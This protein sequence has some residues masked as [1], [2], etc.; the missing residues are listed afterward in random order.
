M[1]KYFWKFVR[2]GNQSR[3]YISL[4]IDSPIEYCPNVSERLWK[5]SY[6][7]L[8]MLMILLHDVELLN[9][10][11]NETG[12]IQKEAFVRAVGE[13]GY[14]PSKSYK[15]LRSKYGLVLGAD[16]LGRHKRGLLDYGYY[17]NEKDIIPIDVSCF[18]PVRWLMENSEIK[19]PEYDNLKVYRK[20][21]EFEKDKIYFDFM[22]LH[23]HMV[24]IVDYMLEYDKVRTETFLSEVLNWT[25]M[26]DVIGNLREMM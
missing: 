5:M 26:E 18:Y 1:S 10:E 17:K 12:G 20:H 14:L 23:K 7:G 19:T 11:L 9:E 8:E 21:K 6:S 15:A 22:P 2:N 3:K 24:V 16:T 25:K 13:L 4:I